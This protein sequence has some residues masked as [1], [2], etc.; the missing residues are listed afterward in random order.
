MSKFYYYLYVETGSNPEEIY[1][2][3]ETKQECEEV[4][5]KL[6][7]EGKYTP[8]ELLIVEDMDVWFDSEEYKELEK[9]AR[10]NRL[11]QLITKEMPNVVRKE[12]N[13][14]YTEYT[15]NGCVI[16]IWECGSVDII[17]HTMIVHSEPITHETRSRELIKRIQRVIRCCEELN[18]IYEECGHYPPE[19][20]Y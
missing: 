2:S 5:Q 12:T 8:E 7:A 20:E 9:Q 13:S 6:I 1:I 10:I 3:T 18:D 19:T 14:D 11:K 16:S 17:F 15:V 4:R